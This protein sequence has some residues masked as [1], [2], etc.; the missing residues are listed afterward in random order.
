MNFTLC[1]FRYQLGYFVLPISQYPNTMIIG[2]ENINNALYLNAA[3]KSK[4]KRECI[5]L[6]EPH[7]GHFNPVSQ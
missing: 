4:C 7:P 5:A 3:S 2:N 1:I 6:C